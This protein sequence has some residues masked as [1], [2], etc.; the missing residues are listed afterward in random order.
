MAF[1][2]CSQ[3]ELAE[4]GT[5][6]PDGMYPMTFTAMQ[7]APENMPQTR[8]SDSENT[9]SWSV[10][11]QIHVTVV[12]GDAKQETICTLDASGNITDYNPQ[13]YWQN[14]DDVTV[15]AWY[16]NIE[17]QNTGTGNTVRLDNQ[18]SGLAYV[19][20]AEETTAK[21][22]DRN[23]ELK[24]SH[25]L[26]KIRVK[27]TGEKAGSVNDV[28]IESYISCTNTN[29]T[30]KGNETSIGEIAMYK[31]N[32]KTYEANVVPEKAIERFKVNDGEWVKLSTPVT[33]VSAGNYHEIT[34]KV[35]GKD[36][37]IDSDRTITG[38]HKPI[39]INGNCTVTFKDANITSDD[40]PVI[41]I[42]DGC[43]PTL[44]FKGTNVLK[45]SITSGQED[46]YSIKLENNA[47]LAVISEGTPIGS[48]YNRI[49][50]KI[51]GDGE[52]WVQSNGH[53]S[54][55]IIVKNGSLDVSG[56]VNLTAVSTNIS[57]GNI[58]NLDYIPAIG[59]AA[60]VSGVIGGNITL[61]N[62]TLKLYAWAKGDKEPQNWVTLENGTVTPDVDG[63]LKSAEWDTEVTLSNN[64]KVTKLKERPSLPDWA[65]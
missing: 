7:V 8:V 4:Q 21:Y 18:S 40:R 60:Y 27:L 35:E 25:Q 65:K 54:P 28:K 34:I 61:S 44:V 31:V 57:W 62:C 22:T 55:A 9:S 11:D 49:R 37:T 23:I 14:T 42:N 19:L 13:L 26:A 33:P 32:D 53:D 47:K 46:E 20:K 51:S 12:P 3:E 58:G 29:G 15:N 1:A 16:S 6:L 52:M 63:A 10:G 5:P 39:I 17:G 2:S 64:V 43:N 45:G 36:V 41:K 56:G 24:F 48:T 38:V 30:V 50:L 59:R